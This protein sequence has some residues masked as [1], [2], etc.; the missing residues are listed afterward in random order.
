MEITTVADDLIIVH[1]GYEVS[2]YEGLDADTEY[3]IHGQT[4]RTLARPQGELLAVIAT[5][6]D[7]HFGETE[8]G[9]IDDHPEGPI[10]RVGPGE[11]PYPI[12]MNRGAIAELTALN[13]LKV[14]V[15]G[16]LSQDGQ[17]EEWAAFEAHY[18]GAFGDRLH[19]VRGNHDAY[20]MQRG[21]EGDQWITVDGLNVALLDTAI[22]GQTTG[23][24]GPQQFEWLET[25]I[26]ESDRAVLL[27]GHHQQFTGDDEGG[28]GG[29]F[30]IH[31]DASMQLDARSPSAVASYS[32]TPPGTPTAIV[33]ARCPTPMPYRRSRLAA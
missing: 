1:D 4:V 23:D 2:R 18:R 30:G 21:Y 29:Y 26:A 28:R 19:V 10:M 7:V 16:D 24:I 3:H 25:M 22:P 32:A 11:D 33:C 13:P 15:K 14:I 31:P 5:V 20:Q 9:R 12:T 17:P 27:M 8:C 6:N